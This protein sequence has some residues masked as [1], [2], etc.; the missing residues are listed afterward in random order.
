[1]LGMMTKT[2]SSAVLVA[3]PDIKNLRKIM[4]KIDS[5]ADDMKKIP[6]VVFVLIRDNDIV[7][8][9]A[10]HDRSPPVKSVLVYAKFYNL[11]LKI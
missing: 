2:K 6:Y 11:R 8:D 10:R 7:P 3:G 5:L 9:T 4:S 1:M